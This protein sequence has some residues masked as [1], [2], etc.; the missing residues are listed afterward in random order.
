MAADAYRFTEHAFYAKGNK[1]EPW[2]PNRRKIVDLLD[3][4]PQ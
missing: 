4:L 3:A 2:A 1:V